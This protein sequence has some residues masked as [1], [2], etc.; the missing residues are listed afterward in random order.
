MRLNRDGETSRSIHQDLV[1][2][3]LAEANQFIDQFL[4][5]V[6]DNHVGHD[7]VDEIE[8][9]ISKRVLVLA[10]KIAIAAER[11]PNIRA[12]LIRAGLT[13]AQYRPGLGNRITMTPVTPHG[14]SRQTQSD[15]FEQR[16]QRALMATANERIL[17]GE[18]YERA[19]VESYN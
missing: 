6:R 5:Y 15:M 8:L 17:L 14:R 1:D 9:P 2:A 7:L 12:L 18:L 4:L 11:R 10:F 19:C 13:L 16:L 3:R